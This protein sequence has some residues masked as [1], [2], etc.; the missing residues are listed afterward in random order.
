MQM[1]MPVFT[2]AC[3]RCSAPAAIPYHYPLDGSEAAVEDGTV[4]PNHE[5]RRPRMRHLA[6]DRAQDGMALSTYAFPRICISLHMHAPHHDFQ[7]GG[8]E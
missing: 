4:Q 8:D 2:A 3:A 7:S 6:P 5:L 1:E